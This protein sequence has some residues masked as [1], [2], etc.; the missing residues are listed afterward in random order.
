MAILGEIKKEDLDG[1]SPNIPEG[2]KKLLKDIG[3][4]KGKN[5]VSLF[6]KDASYSKVRNFTFRKTLQ[7]PL[8]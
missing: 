3:I 2:A 8:I 1:M 6:P 4:I 7:M 5:L